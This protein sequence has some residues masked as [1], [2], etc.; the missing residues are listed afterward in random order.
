MDNIRRR[1][2]MATVVLRI[3]NVMLYADGR[4]NVAL[5][6]TVKKIGNQLISSAVIVMFER[7]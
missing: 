5:L 6:P 4:H 1:L 7:S 2:G 3:T